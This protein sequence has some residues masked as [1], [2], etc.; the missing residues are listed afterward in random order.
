MGKNRR[1]LISVTDKTGLEKFKCLT[2][3]GYQI[4]STG[5]TK[6]ALENAKIPVTAIEDITGFPEMMDGR[7][8]TLHPKIAGG[9][10]AVRDNVKHMAQALE[11]NIE[12]ID[13]VVVNL[14]NFA[15]NPDIEQI[16]IGGPTLIRAASKNGIST[17]PIIDPDDYTWLIA[18]IAA[19]GA[20]PEIW[21]EKLVIKVFRRTG[22]YDIDIADW[23]EDQQRQDKRFLRPALAA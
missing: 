8:K 16:D 2:D 15:A 21:R 23:M 13:I 6:V 17:I 7:V 12:M 1:I 20:I 4:I 11:H 18:E 14:Y 19:I 3:I 10:L 9:I 5:G 22:Q